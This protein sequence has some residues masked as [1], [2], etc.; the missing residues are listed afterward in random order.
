MRVTQTNA[1]Q[2][3]G[4]DSAKDAGRAGAARSARKTD[5]PS[6]SGEA[7]TSSDA[8]KA[9]LSAR[10]KEIARAKAAATSAPDV[11]EGKI[12]ELKQRIAEGRY[13]VEPEA[14]ADKLVNEHLASELG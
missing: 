11:R 2:T 10:G 12:A 6:S 3:Q 7:A 8:V 1:N 9:E 5:H 4:A 13:N 14:V